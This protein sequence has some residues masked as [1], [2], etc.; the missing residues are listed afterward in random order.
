MDMIGK[1]AAG[2]FPLLPGEEETDNQILPK[3]RVPFVPPNPNE[4][5]T[6]ILMGM[7]RALLAQ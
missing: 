5:F 4:F 6:A 3:M 2:E 7:L 1:V